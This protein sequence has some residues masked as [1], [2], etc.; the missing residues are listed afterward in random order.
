MT[1]AV[2]FFRAG[3]TL[4]SLT[5]VTLASATW[6]QG[7][8]VGIFD[9]DAIHATPLQPE[10]VA[11]SVEGGVVTEAIRYTTVPG[12]RPLM[13]LTYKPG[14]KSKP[15]I[16]F[17]RR[18]G[19]EARLEEAKAGF[20]GVSIAPPSGNEDPARID[21]L[22][23]PKYDAPIGYRQYFD[24]DKNQ[25]WLYHNVLA[26][27]RAFDYLA[28][29]PEIDISKSSVLGTEWPGMAVALMHAI[30]D[31]PASYFVW[32]SMGF[33]SDLEGNSGDIKARISREAYEMYSPGAYAEY[34][35]KPIYV[36]NALNSLDS[37]FDALYEFARKLKSP[38]VLA[39]VPNRER[40]ESNQK[41]FSGSSTWQAF[42]TNPVGATPP[43]IGEG[44][45]S[46]VNGKLRYACEATEQTSMAVLVSYGKPGNWSGRTWHRMAM[47][48]DQGKFVADIPV[49]DPEMPIYIMGQVKAARFGVTA[50]APML[51]S[52][53]T[54]GITEATDVFPSELLRADDLYVATGTI[55][56]GPTGL[57]GKLSARILPHWNGTIRLKNVQPALWK[58]AKEI[59]VT[60]KGDGAP[61][62]LN[63]YFA[64]ESRDEL[65][66]ERE[67]FTMVPLLK[68]GEALGTA[69]RQF[70]IPLD[71]IYDLD[72]VDSLFF[73]TGGKPLQIAG[74]S[75]R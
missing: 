31:R 54:V 60:V 59:V 22:G 48:P 9:L 40:Y 10:V 69:W 53:S 20:V 72:R 13:I 28:T 47:K 38:K 58:N 42:W 25:S 52:P 14:T 71:Q 29:R 2:R 18:F 57:N 16:V 45:V 62:P 24:T 26:L 51:V 67:N 23:G 3:L 63:V 64:V 50:N 15:G 46:K 37:R 33:Y 4:V 11:R 66:R 55:A 8:K 36:A 39:L 44:S 6:P 34:G 41:E 75:W 56:A 65:D 61:A 30:D 68:E 19:A 35:K 43:T 5:C 70:V 49:Y 27:T 73:E 12:V 74:L 21:A 17:A 32:N 1:R 7:G